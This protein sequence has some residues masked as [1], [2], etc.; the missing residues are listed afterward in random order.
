M[1]MTLATCQV[2]A[3]VLPLV[4]V[5]LVVERRSMRMAL[6]RRGWFRKIMLGTFEA[7]MFGLVFVVVGTQIEGLSGFGGFIAWLLAGASILGLGVLIL[8]SLASAEADED[9]AEQS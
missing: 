7:S 9:E 2:L 8:A 5:T 6:R 3:T 4:M 1:G